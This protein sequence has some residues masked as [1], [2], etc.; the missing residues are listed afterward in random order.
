MHVLTLP[1][2]F[3]NHIDAP[4]LGSDPIGS[5]SFTST[6]KISSIFSSVRSPSYT[7]SGIDLVSSPLLRYGPNLP[8][9]PSVSSLVYSGMGIVHAKGISTFSLSIFSSPKN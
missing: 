9:L 8:I 6:L 5:S 4:V 7:P 3:F 1:R 2:F